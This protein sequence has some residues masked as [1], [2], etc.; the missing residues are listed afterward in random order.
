M[1]DFGFVTAPAAGAARCS[2]STRCCACGGST[3]PTA[4]RSR[5]SRCGAREQL[6]ADL[7][8]ADVERSRRSTSCSPC[9]LGGATQTIA[10]RSGVDAPTPSCSGCRP[11]RRCCA[12]SGSPRDVDGQPGAAERARLP[13]HR[14]EF[15]V[16]LPQAD[17]SWRPAASASSSSTVRLWPKRWHAE[18]WVC[19]IRGH[20]TPAARA[21]R[22][23]PEDRELGVDL[24]DGRRFSRC[25]R[26][27]LWVEGAPPAPGQEGCEVIPPLAELHLPRRGQPL[28][29]AIIL[30]VI[31][32]DRGLH[33]LLFGLLAVALLVLDTRLFDLQSFAR[34]AADRL[35]GVAADTGPHAS[36]DV[37]SRELHRLAN[38]QRSTVTAL[39]LVAAAYAAIGAVEAVG[40]WL[41]RRWAEYLT[42]V[43]T[44][45]FLPFEIRELLDRVTL[46]RIGA[47]VVNVAILVYLVYSKRLFGVRG[48]AH[49]LH[50]QIDWD[51]I[52]APPRGPMV[53]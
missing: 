22:L 24:P 5:S 34:D 45:G 30:R 44:A 26:C 33:A 15:V 29:D 21:A 13:G 36:H 1:L 42:V 31:A 46:I 49:A 17:R 40:L 27:D 4:S 38:L 7:S 25:F 41:E 51:E 8:R 23:R 50:E 39:A 52:L 19:S 3:W 11:G 18:T 12:A 43:A 2:A 10:R 14:T 28:R 6:G 32:I 20:V 53:S 35:D 37:L 16:D 48:G 9:A 47:L